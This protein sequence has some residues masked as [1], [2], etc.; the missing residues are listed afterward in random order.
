MKYLL[1]LILLASPLTDLERI[2]KVNKIKKE[3]KTAF[4][5]GDFQKA[6]NKYS[7]LL[8][9]M[10]VEDPNINLNLANAYYKI[11]DTTN[12]VNEYQALLKANDNIIKSV[13]HQQ[14]GIIKNR[15]KKF[16]EALAHFKNAIKANP[17]NDE[18]RY[19]YE[20]LK[21]MLEEKE[22][23]EEQNKDQ[24]NKDQQNKDQENKD[25]Q[26]QQ[27]KDQ[28]KKD[29]QNQDKEGEQEKKDQQQQNQDQKKEGE[30]GEQKENEQQPEEK[31]QEPQDQKQQP[32]EGEESDKKEGEQQEMNSLSDKLKEMKISEEKAKMI[33]EA[34]KN[35]EIQYIQ[36]NKRKPK[37][38]KDPEKP[39]W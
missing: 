9:S 12:A 16:D 10:Q 27:Q 21:K 39:D 23:Q 32:K 15:E 35:N 34:L 22:K 17:A 19:N 38:R 11:S 6:I 4:T 37:K 30:E 14:L 20:M 26:D 13:A 24:Q 25:K 3:A 5:T 7:Y 29:Q 8:D 28:K 33:L 2:A 36:Q 1:T 31:K 18:A